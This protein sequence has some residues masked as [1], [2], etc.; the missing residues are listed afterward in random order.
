MLHNLIGTFL[1]RVYFDILTMIFDD[2]QILL[3]VVLL[4]FD[5]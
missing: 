3:R 4:T 1:T 5:I 2:S